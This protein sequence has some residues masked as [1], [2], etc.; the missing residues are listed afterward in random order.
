MIEAIDPDKEP[1]ET[2]ARETFASQFGAAA[3]PFGQAAGSFSVADGVINVPTVSLAAGATTVM[4]DGTLDLN[5][6]ALASDWSL[7][8]NAPEGSEEPQ[9]F[10][11]VLFSGPVAE[12]ERRVDLNP[13]LEVLRARY[14]QRQ[15]DRDRGA[16]GGAAPGRGGGARALRSAAGR[17]AAPGADPRRGSAAAGCRGAAAPGRRARC[18]RAGA[19]GRRPPPPGRL[20]RRRRS[21]SPRRSFSSLPRRCRTCSAK[22]QGEGGR[23]C[24]RPATPA[25][26]PPTGRS[27]GRGE[28]GPS[29][30]P[31]FG[32]RAARRARPSG[33]RGRRAAGRRRDWRRCARASIR[34]ISAPSDIPASSAMRFSSAQYRILDATRWWRGPSA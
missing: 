32:A 18:R 12:P 24:R 20:R 9:P 4:A 27:I 19:A 33:R 26:E 21:R 30:S 6:L 13:L 34:S 1:D 28:A 2:V 8:G 15:L 5:S 7:R 16:G 22:A 11:R 29:R 14:L 23:S 25:R 17:A 10:V 31:S 3:F